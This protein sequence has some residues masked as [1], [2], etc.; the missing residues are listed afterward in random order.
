MLPR[1]I[2]SCRNPA[3]GI[4]KQEPDRRRL[5]RTAPLPLT[6]KEPWI[7][8]RSSLSHSILLRMSTAQFASRC[9]LRCRSTQSSDRKRSRQDY[10]FPTMLPVYEGCPQLESYFQ[11]CEGAPYRR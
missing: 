10:T 2:G 3:T 5:L 4:R 11:S 7:A 6:G 9:F 8:T 1:K